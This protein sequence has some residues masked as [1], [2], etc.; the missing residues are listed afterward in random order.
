MSGPGEW[1]DL[2]SFDSDAKHDRAR[3][4]A[5]EA[6]EAHAREA[7]WNPTMKDGRP[8]LSLASAQ[9]I[10]RYLLEK[11]GSETSEHNT[12]ALIVLD[13]HASNLKVELFDALDDLASARR[14]M[15]KYFCDTIDRG[16]EIRRLREALAAE[17]ARQEF[18]VRKWVKERK[19]L[20][21]ELAAWMQVARAVLPPESPQ[22]SPAPWWQGW[23]FDFGSALLMAS[24][25]VCAIAS[26]VLIILSRT[27]W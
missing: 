10:A 5:V 14:R 15:E 9:T 6:A 12:D 16:R 2:S 17:E 22:P 1:Y 23:G 8:G 4:A 11:F 27:R 26:L 24:F 13:A 20:R 3:D 18:A 21:D 25:T 19:E 7:K